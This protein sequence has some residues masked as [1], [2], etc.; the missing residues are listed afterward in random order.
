[1][2]APIGSL[3]AYATAPG[4]VADDGVGRNGVYT[5]HLLQQMR[6]PGL[7]LEELFRRVRVAVMEETRRQQVPWES[8]SLTEPFVFVPATGGTTASPVAPPPATTP[9]GGTQVA[10]GTYPPTPSA[11][12]A[13]TFVNSIGIQFVLIPAGEFQMGS[14]DGLDSEKPVRPVR[15]STPF[16]L[17]AYEVTQGQWQAIMDSN[18]SQYKGDPN[19]PVESVSW[20]DVQAFIRQLNAKEGGTKYRLPTEAEWEYTARAGTTTAY[21]FGNDER[22]LQE[23]AWCGS[24]AGGKTHPVG[25]LKPNAWGLYDM[26]GNV[27]EWVQDWRGPYSAAAAVAPAGPS[28]GS[29][30]VIRGGGWLIVAGNCRAAYRGR[31]TPGDRAGWLGLRL[32]RTAP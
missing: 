21:S 5:S 16:Y 26:H 3:V 4:K 9:P 29:F 13:K 23:Y 30:R 31:V 18:P 20:E 8:S 24:N 6:V 15:I 32:L 1:M 12:P 14:N 10:V 17:G 25:Q 19:L 11:A 2:E 22:Q 7:T 28:S 27:W